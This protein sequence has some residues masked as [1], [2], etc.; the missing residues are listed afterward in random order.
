MVSTLGHQP[1]KESISKIDITSQGLKEKSN[2]DTVKT[3][4]TR[5]LNLSS[6][7]DYHRFCMKLRRQL[8]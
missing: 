5:A 3:V 6:A 7:N 2:E 1:Y 4:F 8:K